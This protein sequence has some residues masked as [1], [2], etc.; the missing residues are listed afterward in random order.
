MADL[1]KCDRC[2]E[3]FEPLKSVTLSTNFGNRDIL[4]GLISF[5]RYSNDTFSQ[6]DLCP[7]CTEKFKEFMRTGKEKHDD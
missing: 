7:H 3:I 1:K 5:A 2:G 4:P 6:W